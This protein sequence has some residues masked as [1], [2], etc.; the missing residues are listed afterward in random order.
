MDIS[1]PLFPYGVG[2]RG[3]GGFEAIFGH[4]VGK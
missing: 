2:Y 4:L 3:A 1:E